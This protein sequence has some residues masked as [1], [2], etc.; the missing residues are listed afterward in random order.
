MPLIRFLH[1]TLAVTF[2]GILLANYF[3]VYRAIQERQTSL[4]IFTLKKSLF[5]DCV[6]NLPVILILFTTGGYQVSVMHLSIETP[7]IISAYLFFMLVTLL[8]LGLFVL[9]SYNYITMES[10]QKFRGVILL[11]TFYWLIFL[12]LI[13]IIHDAVRKMTFI[14][15]QH[16]LT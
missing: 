1:V 7:W 6:F 13:F 9:K 11:H 5:S 3:Y 14:P 8:W 10:H 4:V 12:I 16:W 2:S 15:W